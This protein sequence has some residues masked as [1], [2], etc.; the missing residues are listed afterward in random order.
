MKILVTGGTGLVGSALKA[1]IKVG[2][3]FDLRITKNAHSLISIHKPTHIIH[4]AAR[5]GGLGG[6]MNYKGEFYYDNI[7]INTNIIEAARLGGIKKL[8]CFLSTC[9]FPDKID[10]PL[11]E[12]KIHLG[13][14]H[15]SNYPYAYA[16]RMADIQIKAYREQY[17]LDYKCVIPTNIYGSNDNFSLIQGH[18][19]P[20]LIHKCYL[21]KQNNT[22]FIVWGSGKPLR[23]FIH[24]EDIARLTEWVLDHYNENEPIILTT[25]EEVE[26]GYVAKLIADAMDFKGKLIFDT[27]KPEGQFRKPSSNEKLKKYLPDFKF[28]PIEEGIIETVNWFV[29]NYDKARK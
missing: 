16:K 28:K 10:Y 7:M 17:G 18:V 20:M 22:D 4:C 3:E 8:V 13:E 21:A 19:I 29:Q 27:T 11:T 26:I 2:S 23:E 15:S 9:I 1:D 25:S 5:V 24:S 12:A 14:P 6:N